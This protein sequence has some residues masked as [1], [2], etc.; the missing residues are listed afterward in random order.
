[1]Q[2]RSSILRLSLQLWDTHTGEP[3]WSSTAEAILSSEAVLQDPVYLEDAA[4]VA[5]GSVVGDFLRGGPL[6]LTRR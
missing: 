5:L 2:T 6:P 3:I 1:M 4:R